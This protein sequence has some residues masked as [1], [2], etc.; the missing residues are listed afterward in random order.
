MSH[1]IH[2]TLEG[3]VI[4]LQAFDEKEFAFYNECLNAYRNNMP[5]GQYLKLIQNPENALMK[6]SPQVTKEIYYSKL[7][8]AVWDLGDRL[9]IRQGH[10]AADHTCPCLDEEPAQQDEFISPYEAAKR[11]GLT[12]PAIHAAIKRGDLAAHQEENGRWKVS[13]RSLEQYQPDLARQA[14]P[15]K[16]G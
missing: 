15:K 5:Y 4:D 3:N 11:K 7:G 13:A 14:A 6:G 12:P 1:N 9:A 8:Q 16:E 2:V 10:M